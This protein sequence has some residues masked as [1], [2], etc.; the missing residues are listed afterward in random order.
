MIENLG[1]AKNIRTIFNLRLFSAILVV[2]FSKLNLIRSMK[3]CREKFPA[4]DMKKSQ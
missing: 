3:I 2:N 1:F 4:H